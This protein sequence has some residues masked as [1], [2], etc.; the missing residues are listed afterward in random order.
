MSTA[1]YQEWPDRMTVEEYAI[2][3]SEK[4]RPLVSLFRRRHGWEPPAE[5]R[6]GEFTLESIGLT[7]TVESLYP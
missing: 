4:N 6:T 5:H 7:L 2:V 1:V 3:W